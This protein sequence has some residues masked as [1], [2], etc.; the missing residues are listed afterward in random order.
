M[1]IRA[2]A[3]LTIALIGFGAIGR[4]VAE[5]LVAAPGGARLVGVLVRS[6]GK[7]AREILPPDVALLD[8]IGG[9][10][11]L[12]P[13]IVVE[14]AGQEALAQYAPELLGAG[15]DV[16]A[17][18]TGALAR[19]GALEAWRAKAEAGG[20]RLFIPAGAIAGLDG[21]GSHR[22]AGLTR[23]IYTST[24]P[25]VAWRGTP[26]EKLLDLGSLQDKQTFFEGTAREAALAYPKNANLAATVALAGMG[27][28]ETRVRL[29][30]DPAAGGNTG[31]IEAESAIGT[32]R[33]EM[34]G[35]AGANPKTSAST[36]YSLVHA[37]QNMTSRIVI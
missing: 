28:D 24:K 34:A 16:M 12:A 22:L 19:P 23:V 9:L 14:C 2:E 29:V 3:R 5:R 21:L 33:V 25:P 6:G 4:V 1:T 18:S 31:V 13:D 10:Q 8:G 17:V 15:I 7:E 26:A 35:Q 11:D 27:L 37:L 30:A 36:A 32:M 20:A